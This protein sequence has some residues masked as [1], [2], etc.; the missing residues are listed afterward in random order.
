MFGGGTQGGLIIPVKTPGESFVH[1]RVTTVN[2]IA[3]HGRN[4]YSISLTQLR[5]GL[6]SIQSCPIIRECLHRILHNFLGKDLTQDAGTGGDGV[7]AR[8]DG[9][10]DLGGLFEARREDLRLI[11]VMMDDA[12]NVAD[13]IRCIESECFHAVEIR[14]DAVRARLKCKKRLIYPVDRCRGYVCALQEQCPRELRE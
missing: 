11:A 10:V 8:E 5:E 7:R 2:P 1:E 14:C 4:I 3:E 6:S 12:G 13:N 9:A